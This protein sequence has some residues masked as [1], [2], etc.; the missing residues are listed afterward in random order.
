[1]LQFQQLSHEVQIRRNDGPDHL[2]QLVRFQQ[3][4]GFVAHDV[5][6]GDRGTAADSGLT[7]Q[8]HGGA[9][10]A[11]VLDEIVRLLKVLLNVL[12]GRI[13]GGDLF[14]LQNGFQQAGRWLLAGHIQHAVRSQR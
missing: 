5:R 3:G 8:Q 6:D 12:M 11:G 9:S 7:V 13:A 1:M 2:Y 14:V 4:H 10:F